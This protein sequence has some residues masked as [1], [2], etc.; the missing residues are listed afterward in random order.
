M[1]EVLATASLLDGST[2]IG[3]YRYNY[4]VAAVLLVVE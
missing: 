4:S 3:T 2:L 1:L